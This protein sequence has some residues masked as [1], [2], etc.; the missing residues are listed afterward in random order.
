MCMSNTQGIKI[1]ITGRQKCVPFPLF[2][3]GNL[4]QFQLAEVSSA[5]CHRDLHSDKGIQTLL[6]RG[7][8]VTHNTN[9][10]HIRTTT[11]PTYP[12]VHLNIRHYK[13]N[14]FLIHYALPFYSL[15]T[16]LWLHRGSLTYEIGVWVGSKRTTS[17]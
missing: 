10:K 12:A 11:K 2:T 9:I 16:E 14:L 6:N 1:H 15:R 8:A 7:E 13:M 5:P 4:L 3:G 17:I